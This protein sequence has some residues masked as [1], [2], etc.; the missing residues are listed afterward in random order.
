MSTLILPP[1]RAPARRVHPARRPFVEVAE[2]FLAD[3]SGRGLSPRTLEQYEWSLRSFLGSLSAETSAVLADLT[4]DAVRAWIEVLRATRRPTSVATAVRA[5]KVFSA[6]TA[7]HG[8]TR[9]DPLA[10]LAIPR[11]PRP[12]VLGLSAAQVGALLKVAGPLLRTAI[13]LLVD[14]GLRASELCGLVLDDVHEDYL[15]VRGKGGYERIAP[16]GEACGSMLAHYL[17]KVRPTASAGNE[18]LLLLPSGAVLRPH[19][20]GELMRDAAHRAGIR[21]IRVS[22]H[23]LRHTFALEFLRNGG[24]ELALQ[25]ALGH[26]SLDM[27]KVYA[28]L[29]EADVIAAQHRASPLDSW[30]RNGRTLG[31]D[32]HRNDGVQRTRPRQARR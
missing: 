16:Y 2:A 17:A 30:R 5:L 19:R 24:G 23:T 3:G 4:P 8:Y 15:F 13:V 6:W 32:M 1:E 14:T 10:L 9:S 31:A 11:A 20:L 7:A 18:P 21:G 22:P 25:K 27:V 29:T 28:E 26:H 12:L